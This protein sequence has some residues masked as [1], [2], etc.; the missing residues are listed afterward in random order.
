MK[1]EENKQKR[2]QRDLQRIRK[3]L[4]D[5]QSSKLL[6]DYSGDDESFNIVVENIQSKMTEMNDGLEQSR[7]RVQQLGN[8]RQWIDWLSRFGEDIELKSTQTPEMR[9]EYLSGL[10]ERVDVDLDHQTNSHII[11]LHFKLGLVGDGIKYLNQGNRSQGYD[12]V[13]GAKETVFE[14]PFTENRGRKKKKRNTPVENHS[15]VTDFA[16][17]RG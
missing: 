17:L 13:E 11:S 14:V 8:E 2:I 12:L 4:A 16:R 3:T 1:K 10:L 9:K 7:L 5:L 6:G 15:T